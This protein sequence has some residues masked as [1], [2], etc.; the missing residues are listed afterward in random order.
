M[1]A[2]RSQ[3]FADAQER[4]QTPTGVQRAAAPANDPPAPRTFDALAQ[5]FGFK[6]ARAVRNWCQRRGV[7]YWRD[8]GFS[9]ADRNAVAARIMQP[10]SLVV[11]E[12]PPPSVAAWVDSTIAGG[13][14]R[15]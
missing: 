14:G 2:G 8:G 6:N 7:P 4:P 9:W 11:P 3:T 1:T 13:K 15:G 10:A 5:E 12:A